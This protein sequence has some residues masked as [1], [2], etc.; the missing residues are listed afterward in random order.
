MDG[1]LGGDQIY[2]GGLAGLRTIRQ[3]FIHQ[4]SQCDVIIIA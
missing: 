2:F 3:Y 1:N 4:T